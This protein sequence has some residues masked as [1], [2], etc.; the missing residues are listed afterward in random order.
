MDEGHLSQVL[1]N[2]VLNARDAMPTGGTSDPDHRFA[3]RAE[4]PAAVAGFEE[5]SRRD[6]SDRHGNG[7]GRG[8][9]ES[10]IRAVLHDQ[11]RARNRPRAVHRIWRRS[12]GARGDRHPERAGEGTSVRLFFPPLP[13]GRTQPAARTRASQPSVG[14]AILLAEDDPDVRTTLAR[15]LRQAG[16]RVVEVGDVEAGRVVVRERGGGI[17]R[18]RDRRHHAG[19]KHAST[20]RRFPDGAPGRTRRRLFRLRRRRAVDARLGARTFEFI[21]KPFSPS[22]LVARLTSTGAPS[23]RIPV[24]AQR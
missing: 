24:R 13:D 11:G 12:T 6:R 16:H 21:P 15:A 3:P 4:L 2:I 23:G 10:R 18:P 20:D 5:R 19:R 14:Q 1:L 9:A 8:D 22:E 7:H 17:R